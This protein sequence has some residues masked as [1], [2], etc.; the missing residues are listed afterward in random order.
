[1]PVPTLSPE[2]RRAASARAVAA[3]RI[4][5]DVARDLK[6]G[7][8]SLAAVLERS[9]E[10]DAVAAMRV[11]AVVAALPRYGP[12]RSAD[13]LDALGISPG[14][15]LRGLGVTQRAALLSLD[16]RSG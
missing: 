4:R 6:T 14:R 5:A 1:M 11:S 8:L 9:G 2:Q 16:R 13:A 15:R 10:D 12:V 7:R 3:R